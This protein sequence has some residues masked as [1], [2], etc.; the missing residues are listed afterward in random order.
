MLRI[1]VTNESQDTRFV[2]QAG[3]LE[4]GRVR[5]TGLARFVV[6]DNTA[7][8][9]QAR[10]E[11]IH[12]GRGVRLTNLSTSQPITVDDG[13]TVDTG[14]AR[15][16]T[17]PTAVSFGMTLL[18]IEPAAGGES[19]DEEG[20]LTI[21]QPVRNVG[22]SPDAVKGAAAKIGLGK[23]AKPAAAPADN[24][25]TMLGGPT[26]QGI[27]T[28]PTLENMARWL[29]TVMALQR[30]GDAGPEFYAVT[31]KTLVDMIGLDVGMVLLKTPE[32]GWSIA[33]R[34]AANEIGLTQR[35]SKTVLNRVAAHRRTFY[36][37][38]TEST[39]VASLQ[40]AEAVVAS[41][42]F[43]VNDEVVGVLYG[44]RALNIRAMALG[45]KPLQAQL[46]Q[47]LSAAVGAALTRTAAVRTRV[48][49]EQFFSPELV[50]ELERDPK[51]LEGR[52]QDVTILCSDLRG[53]TA[54][55]EKLEAKDT[56][57]IIRDLMEV[58]T[59]RIVETGGVIVDY[60]GDGIL[61]MWNAPVPQADHAL[62]AARSAFL[63]S[64]E[65]VGLNQ[66][67][68]ERV[69]GPLLLGIGVNTGQC[70]VGNTGSSRKLKYGPHGYNVNLAS[71]VQDATKK[72][73]VPMLVSGATRDAL[74][75]GHLTRRV[76]K[77][78]LAGIQVPVDLVELVG[79]KPPYP[80][81][82]ERRDAYEAALTAYEEKRWGESGRLIKPLI[83]DQSRPDKPT[84]L[85]AQRLRAVL[86][87]P[88]ADFDPVWDLTQKG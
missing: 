54:L 47:L 35:F 62:R 67:W 45:V 31:A 34:Q 3:P 13:S 28:A 71:R 61:A 9:D 18:E 55:S 69:G 1:H 24:S 63:M 29:E 36:Q 20:F 19:P 46:T 66:R 6:E 57:A 78:R 26:V 38:F 68:A 15:D 86:K 30:I 48:Q 14:Q 12:G 50:R 75:P 8:R 83:A 65:M 2:H 43:G 77:A 59:N 10:I 70:Q 87:E 22:D 88:P 37:D 58:L 56:C 33:A 32:G 41:P 39:T 85:L 23:G 64:G 76:C 42:I 16:L 49:F 21:Q 7:S 84:L 72:L 11:E 51:L 74:P 17:L 60:A 4:F 44:M 79:E 53:F 73:G 5:R 27:D 52:A 82:Q 25:M 80:D 40:N 81:W